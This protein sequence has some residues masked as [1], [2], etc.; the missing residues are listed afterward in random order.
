M[1]RSGERMVSK[2]IRLRTQ[3]LPT[4]LLKAC[5]YGSSMCLKQSHGAESLH[6]QPQH[7]LPLK[8]IE[9]ESKHVITW[10]QGGEGE[11]GKASTTRFDL[12]CCGTGS[13]NKVDFLSRAVG[14]RLSHGNHPH[15]CWILHGSRRNYFVQGIYKLIQ[16]PH[17]L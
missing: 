16:Q 8:V 17:G 3:C 11:E 12:C 15:P 1:C 7:C 5:L 14:C 4:A 9:L 10:G 13:F 6:S 2:I